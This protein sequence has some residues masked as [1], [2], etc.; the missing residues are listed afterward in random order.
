MTE[1][2][3]PDQLVV[4]SRSDCSP[5]LETERLILRHLRKS[6]DSFILQLLNDPS[7]IRFIGDRGARN[8]YD[9]R[10]YIVE[11]PISSYEKHGFGLFLTAL[12]ECHTP[13]GICGLVKRKSLPD[14]DI[15]F[16]FLPAYCELG[17]GYEAASTII[18]Y[19][20]DT[21]G[22][23]RILAITSPDNY[24]SQKLLRKIGLTFE[25]LIQLSA[26]EEPVRLYALN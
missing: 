8:I 15:G 16:A 25:R 19:G 7:F 4:S 10:R 23:E 24:N 18:R 2:S 9:A 13:I 21:L 14:A 5:V 12:K 26:D 11:G 20:K 6:D 22:L 1:R 17:Y 3:Q